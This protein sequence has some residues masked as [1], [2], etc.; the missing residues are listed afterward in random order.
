MV[1]FRR[2]SYLYL[3]C[4]V[5]QVGMYALLY[6]HFSHVQTTI[7]VRPVICRLNFQNAKLT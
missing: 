1:N 6:A 3:S 4:H 7:A 5:V 2:H